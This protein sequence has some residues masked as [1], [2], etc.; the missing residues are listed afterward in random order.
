MTYQAGIELEAKLKSGVSL[1]EVI[2]AIRQAGIEI[3]DDRYTHNGDIPVTGWKVVYDGTPSQD[4]R[5]IWEFVTKPIH[6]AKTIEEMI[7]EM[8]PVLQQFCDVDR[9]CG[10]HIHFSILDKYHFK[11]RVDTTTRMGRLKALRNKPS[12][13]FVAELIRNYNYFQTVMDS[14]VSPS[15]RGNERVCGGNEAPDYAVMSTK[16][17]VKDWATTSNAGAETLQGEWDSARYHKVNLLALRRFGTVE[18]RQHQGTLNATKILNWMKLM[19]RFTTRAWD[20]NYKDLD[21]RDFDVNVDGLFDFL[22]LGRCDR[23]LREYY[24]KRASG[25]GYH[26]LANPELVARRRVEYARAFARLGRA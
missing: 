19:E 14:F 25:F 11:R 20:R 9:D 1:D 4:G 6:G 22:G 7:L 16:Q 12:K 10:Y 23:S 13:L 3:R 8:C 21:C 24:R 15:R 26:R 18:Y 2:R 5:D 17:D